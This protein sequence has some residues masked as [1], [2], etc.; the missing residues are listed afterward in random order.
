MYALGAI[1]GYGLLSNLYLAGR[2]YFA[3]RSIPSTCAF[4]G[5]ILFVCCDL[6]VAISYLSGTGALPAFLQI[7]ANYFAWVFYYPSQVLI[8]NSSELADTTSVLPAPAE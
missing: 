6:C 7:F 2:W 8:S 1:Y 4:Y 5:F 3:R